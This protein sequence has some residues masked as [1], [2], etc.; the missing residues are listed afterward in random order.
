MPLGCWAAEVLLGDDDDDMLRQVLLAK[1]TRSLEL[2]EAT[3]FEPLRPAATNVPFAAAAAEFLATHTT[4]QVPIDAGLHVRPGAELDASTA[5]HVDVIHRFALRKS[6]S[7]PL[8]ARLTEWALHK[9]RLAKECEGRLI[10]IAAGRGSDAGVNKTNVGGFQ[11]FH[12]LFEDAPAPVES[13]DDDG[14]GDGG[15]GGGDDGEAKRDLLILRSA[16]SAALDEA[17]ARTGLTPAEGEAEE[18]DA[19]PGEAAPHRPAAGEPHASYAWLNVNRS[20]DSNF[21]HTHQVDLWSAVYYLNDGEPNAPG[22]AS[23]TS[24]HMVFRAGSRPVEEGGPRSVGDTPCRSYFAVPPLPGT[25]WIFPGS[26]PH[27]VMPTEL[28]PGLPEPEIPR[29]SIGVNFD[30]ATPPLPRPWRRPAPLAHPAR[31]FGGETEAAGATAAARSVAAR[32]APAEAAAAAAAMDAAA[33]AS[34][35]LLLSGE[36]AA[37]RGFAP[38]EEVVMPMPVWSSDEES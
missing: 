36:D 9:E 25:L 17:I 12:D 29:I 14:D 23:P 7:G 34:P 33:S 8:N 19:Y 13:S 18:G 10:H 32:P 28:P 26:V 2:G 35:F 24:G 5:G 22:F 37:E 21:M 16:V 15:G 31:G 30:R 1:K 20:A 4:Y 6:L 3:H 27:T 38:G 11:S